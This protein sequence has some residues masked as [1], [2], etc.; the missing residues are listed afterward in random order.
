MTADGCERLSSCSPCL[1][2]PTNSR[3]A[4]A[5]TNH[6]PSPSTTDSPSSSNRSTM[7]GSATGSPL[8]T[9]VP[10]GGLSKKHGPAV[11]GG[12]SDVNQCVTFLFGLAT[13]QS[14]LPSLLSPGGGLR[15]SVRR[16][17]SPHSVND[18]H[19]TASESG[20][21]STAHRQVPALSRSVIALYQ[22]SITPELCDDGGITDWCNRRHPFITIHY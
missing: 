20:V 10:D 3:T 18:G 8:V 17:P 22:V 4:Q 6:F 19:F 1:T 2:T 7:A 14:N 16:V 5:S 12:P 15:G 9:T 13:P 21:R 11:P